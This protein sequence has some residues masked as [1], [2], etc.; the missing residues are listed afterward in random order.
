[1]PDFPYPSRFHLPTITSL[2]RET[3]LN[4]ANS[5]P[6]VSP[7][8]AATSTAWPTGNLVLLVPFVIWAPYLVRSVFWLNGGTASGNVDCGVYTQDLNELL[9]NAGTT[10]Q[11]GTTTV[12]AVTL[13]SAYLIEPGTYYMALVNSGTSGTFRCNVVLTTLIL[14]AA[15]CTQSANG[16]LPLAASQTA[17]TPSSFNDI[18]PLFGI[19]SRISTL[20]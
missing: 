17:T 6:F 4:M 19:S 15:G 2:S 10:A 3:P 14:E 13:S 18:M 9:F 16:S 11:S 20:I 12:Q 5:R 8:T 1:M 7:T